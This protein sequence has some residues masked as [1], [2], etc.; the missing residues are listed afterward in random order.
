MLHKRNVC[1]GA[2]CSLSVLQV[3]KANLNCRY[4]ENEF[5]EVEDVVIV[6]V[7]QIADMGAY[8]KLLEYN[9][10]EGTSIQTQACTYLLIFFCGR[11]DFAQ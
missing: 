6:E 8:V 3:G 10:I 7:T 9:N 5:P 1:I 11:Y 2:S 4:Y